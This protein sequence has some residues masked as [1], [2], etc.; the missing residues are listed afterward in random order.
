MMV[1]RYRP[2]YRPASLLDRLLT[3][4]PNSLLNRQSTQDNVVAAAQ[5]LPL[6]LP[7]MAVNGDLML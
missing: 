4:P 5:L 2:R 6:L 3:Q 7:S 1:K